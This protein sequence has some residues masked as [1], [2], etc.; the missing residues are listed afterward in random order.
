MFY[1]LDDISLAQDDATER[2]GYVSVL[3]LAL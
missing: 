1:R 2:K 3:M